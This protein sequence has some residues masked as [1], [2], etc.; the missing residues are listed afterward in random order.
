[1]SRVIVH[2]GKPRPT[3]GASLF[4]A[5][6]V[7]GGVDVVFG[8]Y[9]SGFAVD[10]DHGGLVDDDER[11]FAGVDSTDSEVVEFAGAAQGEFSELVDNIEADPVVG[12]GG[13][14]AGCG[15]DRGGV[16]SSRSGTGQSAVGAL[17]VVNGPKV[18]ELFLEYFHRLGAGLGGEPFFE[19]LVESFNF[20]L[21][22]GVAGDPFFWVI[23]NVVSRYS[24]SFFPPRKRAV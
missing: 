18:I 10:D 8:E 17:I 1:M 19:G 21:G 7:A 22:L 6:V 12:V 5:P 15:F 20:S 16:S 2:I 9:F 11:G 14:T 24:N 13:M 3:A 4:V 23:P